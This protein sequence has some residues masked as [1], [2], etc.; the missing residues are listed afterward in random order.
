MGGNNV[1]QHSFNLSSTR[2]IAKNSVVVFATRQDSFSLFD[3]LAP[4]A[5]SAISGTVILMAVAEM[6]Y[7]DPATRSA[8]TDADQKLLLALFD[9]EAFDY[10]GSGD[11]VH[12]LAGNRFTLADPYRLTSEALAAYP[13]LNLTHLSH[14]IELNQLGVYPK[15]QKDPTHQIYLHSD[16]KS[17]VPGLADLIKTVKESAQGLTNISVNEVG[18]AGN[19]LP[20]S[21]AQ[22]FLR[23]KSQIGDNFAVLVA[24]NHRKTYLNKYYN[25]FLED[26]KEFV[27]LEV[28]SER[29]T[30]LATLFGRVLYQLVTKTPGRF[31]STLSPTKTANKK[32]VEDLLTCY[33]NDSNCR[34]FQEV[35]NP[36]ETKLTS[37]WTFAKPLNLF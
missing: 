12:R 25:S 37:K 10:I 33:L 35:A 17:V 30:D 5:D 18:G 29:L 19:P 34:L 13:T 26:G 8:I 27:D 11:T 32:T 28:L 4:G 7:S 31:S 1:F 9:G 16:P 3:G 23:K 2:K 22:S 14:F 6:L 20:P 36:E 15:A 21:S 24:T